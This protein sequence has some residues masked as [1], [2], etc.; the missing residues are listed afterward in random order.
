MKA[1]LFT[2]FTVFTSSIFS[3]VSSFADS[4]FV[5]EDNKQLG[6]QNVLKI[7]RAFDAK[8]NA[9]R[10]RLDALERIALSSWDESF[11][12]G[13]DPLREQKAQ[14]RVVFNLLTEQP[15]LAAE[16]LSASAPPLYD[17]S[18]Q[19]ERARVALSTAAALQ[20]AAKVKALC[21]NVPPL[22][23][24]VDSYLLECASLYSRFL[25]LGTKEISEFDFLNFVF[26]YSN[27]AAISHENKLLL[28][29]LLAPGFVSLSLLEKGINVLQEILDGSG[30]ETQWLARAYYAQGLL[31]YSH[32]ETQ[33]AMVLWRKL[34]GDLPVVDMPNFPLP[35]RVDP[36]TRSQ[37]MLQIARALAARGQQELAWSMYQRML[38]D[39]I[40]FEDA[41]SETLSED[42]I[43]LNK[44]VFFPS[45]TF[46]ARPQRSFVMLESAALASRLGMSKRAQDIYLANLVD[47]TPNQIRKSLVNWKSGS[48]PIILNSVA[49]ELLNKLGTIRADLKFAESMAFTENFD[50]LKT[51]A[52]ALTSLLEIYPEFSAKKKQKR[53]FEVWGPL[54]SQRY[55]AQN[56]IDNLSTALIPATISDPGALGRRYVVAQNALLLNS[57]IFFEFLKEVDDVSVLSWSENAPAPLG[58]L[59]TVVTQPAILQGPDPLAG[60][61]EFLLQQL[62]SSDDFFSRESSRLQNEVAKSNLTSLGN[63]LVTSLTETQTLHARIGAVRFLGELVKRKQ[64]SGVQVNFSRLNEIEELANRKK[65]EVV[66]LTSKTTNALLFLQFANLMREEKSAEIAIELNFLRSKVAAAQEL[67]RTH[68]SAVEAKDNL[69]SLSIQKQVTLTWNNVGKTAGLITK[70]AQR[71][72]DS[73]VKEKRDLIT[74]SNEI[75]QHQKNWKAVLKSARLQTSPRLKSELMELR[76]EIVGALKNREGEALIALAEVNASRKASLSEEQRKLENYQQ[77]RRQFLETVKRSI[78]LGV[79][80]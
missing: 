10:V 29:I 52:L 58:N 4:A 72:E 74:R 37:S 27:D 18:L 26:R 77:R 66:L 50:Q 65:T 68:L 42:W 35:E 51:S 38:D 36:A 79:A 78:D 54:F 71:L 6:S 56:V 63:R 3:T 67:V 5:L 15:I 16:E 69:P 21:S 45:T 19:N 44:E 59:N 33:R 47:L 17:R 80:R 8:N 28:T 22:G 20:D 34:C 57:K 46:F 12:L 64:L 76:S 73:Y 30:K 55:E 23:K 70:L 7:F 61:R 40:N 11:S 1:F 49:D 39:P 43:V 14:K 25:E 41:R 53:I 48:E 62:S 32:G 24:A 75:L 31:L 60:K 13:R 2:V 9:M